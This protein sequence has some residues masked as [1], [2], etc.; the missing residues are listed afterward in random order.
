MS[1]VCPEKD[2]S[3]GDKIGLGKGSGSGLRLYRL[4]LFSWLSGLVLMCWVPWLKR[5]LGGFEA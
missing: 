1:C 5:D 2:K 3:L 4:L